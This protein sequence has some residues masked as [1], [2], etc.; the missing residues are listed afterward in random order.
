HGSFALVD[1]PT[2]AIDWVA[3]TAVGGVVW[4]VVYERTRNLV[5]TSV[6]HAMSWTVPF[7]LLPLL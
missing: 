5:V 3:S 7:S 1:P 4:G 2:H 6:S